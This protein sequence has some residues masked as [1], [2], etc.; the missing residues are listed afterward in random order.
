MNVI[1]FNNV[2]E[3][4]RIKFIIDEKVSWEE[5]WAL[6]DVNVKVDKGEVVGIIGHNGAGKTTLLRLISGML[7]PDKGKINVHGR[8]STLMELGAGFNPEFTGTE[9]II[10]NA[11]MYG[12]D[13]DVLEQQMAKII[14]FADLG[15]FIDAPIKYYS[16]GMYM[17][18]AFA[19]AIFVEPDILLIDDILAVGDEE[20]RQKCIK[21]IFEL[22][23]MGKTIILVSHDMG[24]VTKLC[25]RVILLE[26]GKIIK[27]GMPEKVIQHYLETVGNKDGIAILEKDRLR[28]VFNNGRTSLSYDTNLLTKGMGGYV[29]FLDPSIDSWLSSFNLSWQIKNLSTDKIIVEGRSSDGA[30]LQLWTLQLLNEGLRWKVE[31]KEGTIKEAHIDLPILPQYK[32]WL[33]LEKEEDFPPFV[34]RDNWQDI[35]LN[36]LTEG[37]L[38]V[39]QVEETQGIPSMILEVEGKDS[40]LR[41]FNTGYEQETRIIQAHFDRSKIISV[42]IRIFPAKEQ[43]ED[44]IE[45]SRQT[46]LLKQ[47]AEEEKLRLQRTISSGNLRL[48]ADLENKAI[49]LYYKDREI[50]AHTGLSASFLINKTW[51]DI[52]SAEWQIT[53]EKDALLLKFFWKS[54]DLTQTWK[55]FFREKALLWQADCSCKASPILELL[56]FGLSLRPEYKTFFCG[57]QQAQFPEEFTV[58][59]DISVEASQSELFGLR[60][61]NELPAVTLKNKDNLTCIVQNSDS[62]FSCRVLQLALPKE[63][64]KE[65][66]SFGTELSILEDE[67][68]I[69]NYVKEK[70]GQLLLKQQA[71]KGQLLLKQQAEEGKLRLQRTISSGNLRLFAD[72]ENKAIRLYYKDREITKGNGLNGYFLINKTWYDISS[73]E[74]QITN[75]KDALLLKFFW[76]SFDLTQ[77]WKVFFREKALLWQADCS[78]KA[79]PILELL[80]FG[81][82][83]RP[84]YK[85]FF[86]GHQQ[87]QFPE[88]FTVWQDISVEASQSELF[89][90]RK[91]NELPAVTL[92]NKDN[93]T[94]I[95]QNSDSSFSCRVLQLALPK[96]LMKEKGSFGTEL[97]I[98]ED[99]TLI[100]N[101]VKEKKGQL[102]LKQQAEKE[103]LR[104]Q[105]TISSG[106]LRLFADLE[107]KAIR[108]YY[109]DREIT[110]GIGLYASFCAS[111]K[112]FHLDDAQWHIQKI[113]ETKLILILNYTSLSLLQFWTLSCKEDGALDIKI[114][115]ESNGSIYMTN[116]EVVLELQ[117]KYKDW[118]TVHEQGDFLVKRYINNIAPIRLKDSKVS[119]VFL[120]S[121]TNE[122]IPNLFFEVSSQL[123]NRILSIYKRYI[124]KN[125]MCICLDSSLIIPKKEELIRSGRHSYFEGRIVLDKD[126]KITE[127]LIVNSSP[128]LNRDKLSFVFDRGI[129]R[130]FWEQRELT[131]GL[132]VYASVRSLGIW[133]DSYQASWQIH[134]KEKNKI[135]VSGDWS[136]IPISQIWQIELINEN[137]ISWKVDIEILEEVNLEIEQA[138]LMLSS[139]YKNWIIPGFHQGEFLDEYTQDYDIIPFRFWY[140]KSREIGA[141][142][143]ILPKIIFKSDMKDGVSRAIVENTDYFYRARLLQYQKTNSCNLL[144]GKYLYFKGVAEIEPEG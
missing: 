29:V 141:K 30:F 16:Q 20:A 66:G 133:Y 12:L 119:K 38:G 73:A 67:T 104:L 101:Y 99:E 137:I 63:L 59:Q 88:E 124:E 15:R 43:F 93:L 3:K 6:D 138:N 44:Y 82:S 130:I 83:L 94:C 97:S 47:Q 64:M 127:G 95:V 85:T 110:K 14:E 103:K 132:G 108:L 37:M 51:Y 74:W 129:G 65:K 36:K 136:H 105:R 91:A 90:L 2:W 58:W 122:S 70:K 8:V 128:A 125:N 76:K 117:D 22:K 144:P 120:R 50:T 11:R 18:L 42:D 113:S 80:K 106:N 69:D 81:L 33:S 134:N 32:K 55:V 126:I 84:E 68:L 115:I 19:L 102:L 111:Q 4:Y 96:E 23:G 139:E 78:C 89:G 75:E 142:A 57:H 48:F 53:N 87:A 28:V 140:G 27:E 116:C 9:N 112:R 17:R 39:T 72:L 35:G 77:T 131:A 135:C 25:N 100:D 26:K 46:F 5:I 24:M 62:S 92:K 107:N 31:M 61:A 114:E 98:L 21:K 86:C 54:F 71:E 109:K 45:K 56:K 79:S 52:S 123:D 118:R 34:H 10:I 13:K 40:K 121:E 41:L 1:E 7:I 143:K 60:K 49:R